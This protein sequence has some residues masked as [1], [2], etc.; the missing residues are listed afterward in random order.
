[1]W[2]KLIIT[3]VTLFLL[4][5]EYFKVID[6]VKKRN[7]RKIILT[8]LAVL[9]ILSFV[10][11]IIE[12]NDGNALVE[13]ANKIIIQSDTLISNTN[14]IIIGLGKNINSVEK[15]GKSII[16]IDSVLKDVRDSVSNQVEILKNV[17]NK[18]QELVRLEKQQFEQDEAKIVVFNSN[19]LLLKN[20]IDSTLFDIKYGVTNKGYRNATDI[21][22]SDQIF[23]YN[24]ALD[25]FVRIN[26][27]NN[28]NFPVDIPGGSSGFYVIKFNYTKERLTKEFDK[29]ILIIKCEYKDGISKKPLSYKGVF[30]VKNLKSPD[31]EFILLDNDEFSKKINQALFRENLKEYL[32]DLNEH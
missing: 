25:R 12:V 1:M 6:K 29:I 14:S 24:I 13:K 18:S 20:K 28:N 26:A 7:R 11:I 8:S 30:I 19:I 31:N 17:V 9:S 22:L 27:P 23:L 21:K 2:I 32:I 16:G 3:I 4:F 10:D 15:T 5:D